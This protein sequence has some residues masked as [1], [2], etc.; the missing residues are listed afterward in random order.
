MPTGLDRPTVT[1]VQAFYRVG[2]AQHLA[3]LQV[4]VQERDELFPCVAPEPNDRRIAE[5]P[6]GVE[7]V[8]G[9]GGGLGVD[10]V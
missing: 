1:R 7:V 10:G 5:A 9:S 2:A 3:D 6:L 4:V 8:Q